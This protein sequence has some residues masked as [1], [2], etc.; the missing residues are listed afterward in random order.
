MDIEKA[1]AKSC[2]EYRK[3]SIGRSI[4]LT[5]LRA[6][7][8][9]AFLEGSR[10]CLESLGVAVPTPPKPMKMMKRKKG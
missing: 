9:N 5:I 4:P 7:Y 1:I 10:W 2:R 3:T 6:I 8:R